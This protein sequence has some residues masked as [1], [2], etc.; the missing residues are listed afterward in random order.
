MLWFLWCL[1]GLR[2]SHFCRRFLFALQVVE[3]V[4]HEVLSRPVG[5]PDERSGGD[6]EE[7]H[8][9]HGHLLVGVE[10]LW[11]DVLRHRHVLL[12]GPHVL[13]QRDHVHPALPQR[14]HGRHHLRR[15]LTQAKHERRLGDD[16]GGLLGVA[17]D[18]KALRP[19]RPPVP[20]GALQP[21]HRLDVV[22]EDVQARRCDQRRRRQVP[23]EVPHQRLHPDRP[24]RRLPLPVLAA[25]LGIGVG[26][27]GGDDALEL[28][29]GSSD[30]RRALVGEVVAIDGGEDDVVDAPLRH[31]PGHLGR[32][33]RVGRGRGAG[34]LHRA[35]PAR[36]G[37]RVAQEHDCR[38]RWRRCPVLLRVAAAPALAQVRAPRLLAHR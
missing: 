25:V 3:V 11:G 22:R 29:D 18:G 26:C 13:P 37:A 20:H 5:G 15:R 31:G 19:R 36:A 7:P 30:V 9:F 32:L 28:L 6:V 24:P 12:G 14:R 8:F 1:P 16:A 34:R 35:E 2:H 33:A 27:G 17:E 38:G 4:V 23:V 10:G 21:L